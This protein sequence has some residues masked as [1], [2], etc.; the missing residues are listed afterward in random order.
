MPRPPNTRQRSLEPSEVPPTSSVMAKEPLPTVQADDGEQPVREKLEKT[1]IDATATEESLYVGEDD[2]AETD[3]VMDDTN[4]R[5]DGP[6]KATDLRRKRSA[7]EV[8]EEE[9]DDDDKTKNSKH[10]RQDTAEGS[11]IDSDVS[12]DISAADATP[13]EPTIKPTDEAE[14]DESDEDSSFIANDK[15][16]R[17]V[18]D[19]TME[20]ALSSPKNKRNRAQFLDDAVNEEASN[21]TPAASQNKETTSTSSTSAEERSTKR[22]RSDSPP[23]RPLDIIS[24]PPIASALSEA[25]PK[26]PAPETSSSAFAASGFSARAGS[27]TSGFGTLGKAS[28]G[29]SPF[30]SAAAASPSLSKSPSIFASASASDETKALPPASAFGSVLG[31][32]SPFAAMG[33]TTASLGSS[34]FGSLLGGAGASPFGASGSG[35]GA[36]AGGPKLSSFAGGG[37]PAITGLSGRAPK[38]F[39]AAPDEDDEEEDYDEEGEAADVRSPV[40]DQDRK[41]PRFHEQ[42]GMEHAAVLLGG[43]NE[44]L[45]ATGEE[46]EETIFSARAKLFAFISEE[47]DGKKDWRERGAGIL[48]VN[49]SVDD[50]DKKARLLMRADGSHRVVLNSPIHKSLKFGNVS[51]EKPT[52]MT[53][54]FLGTLPGQSQLVSMQL[55]VRT[56][57]KTRNVQKTS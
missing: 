24:I 13:E 16:K 42:E 49:V 29:K 10:V 34:G 40:S 44:L 55:R 38:P 25:K 56:H 41:D 39:G 9:D 54:L 7:K 52:G 23:N 19:D 47:E 46:A 53:N 57:Q 6:N 32:K 5:L 37:G 18:L 33:A 36:L 22:Q 35:F 45:V 1:S 48:K 8:E 21:E 4:G 20:P 50:D 14:V 30:A 51:G 31:A 17:M 27:S 15:K 2:T 43:A 28:E 3:E 11:G 12:V 26:S